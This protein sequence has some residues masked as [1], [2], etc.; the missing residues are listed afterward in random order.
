MPIYKLIHHKAILLAP[1]V[2]LSSNL[3]VGALIN[4]DYPFKSSSKL[5]VISWATIMPTIFF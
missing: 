5:G 2:S 3:H 4:K 1:K